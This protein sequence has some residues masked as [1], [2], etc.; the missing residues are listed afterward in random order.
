MAALLDQVELAALR[1]AKPAQAPGT[2]ALPRGAQPPQ[3]ADDVAEYYRRLGT[4]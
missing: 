2:R 4:R 1:A 3:R